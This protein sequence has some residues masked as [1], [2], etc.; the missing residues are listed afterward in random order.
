MVTYTLGVKPANKLTEAVRKDLTNEIDKSEFEMN[1]DY[2]EGRI[3]ASIEHHAVTHWRCQTP[4]ILR[5]N[6]P[7]ERRGLA[8]YNSHTEYKQDKAAFLTI[9]IKDGTET[10]Q[11]T[12]DVEEQSSIN[13]PENV[14]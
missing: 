4:H 11:T 9:L 5:Y 3:K 8:I 12:E 13:N 10:A 14:E 7:N 6:M 1:F 2:W